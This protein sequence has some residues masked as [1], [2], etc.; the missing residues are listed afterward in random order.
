MTTVLAPI[1]MSESNPAIA[2][3]RALRDATASTTT[4]T[5]FR[6]RVAPFED[7]TASEQL[8]SQRGPI[9]AIARHSGVFWL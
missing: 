9:L 3:D 7:E 2:T 4:P 5:T 6:A 8:A 1:S